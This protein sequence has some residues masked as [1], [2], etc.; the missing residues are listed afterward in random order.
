M[1]VLQVPLQAP[2]PTCRLVRGRRVHLCSCTVIMTNN[3]CRTSSGPA[4]ALALALASGAGAVLRSGPAGHSAPTLRET[5]SPTS[6]A[7]T[8]RHVF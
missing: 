4:C 1:P 5:S 6:P 8:F 3:T 7:R 2:P